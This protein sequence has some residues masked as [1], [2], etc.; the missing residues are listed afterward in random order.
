[1]SRHPY[2]YTILRYRH[3]PVS[4]EQLNVGVIVHSPERQFLRGRFRKGYGRLSKAFPDVDGSVLR[5]DLQRIERAF[6]KLSKR[7]SEDLFF[8]GQTASSFARQVVAPDDGSLLWSEIGSGTTTDPESTL[9]KLFFR[10]VTQY[11][12]T[13]TVRRTDADVWRP[14]R[15]KL[16]ELKVASIFEK[17]TI[18][19]PKDEVEFEH[20][21]K[22][23]RWH[24]Y[25]PLSFDLATI[26]GI[27][28]KAARWVGHMVGLS[29]ASEQF[30]PY[31]IVGKPSE[32]NLIPAYNRAVS[33]IAD[34]PMQPTIV[35]EDEVDTFASDLADRV[36]EHDQSR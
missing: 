36:N 7:E 32:P 6:E 34:A 26:D 29:S 21:W 8:A 3:D 20:A 28:E 10:F 9:E 12:E 22:N 31:F 16:M 23:G 4:G 19:S 14:F 11:E 13:S 35:T 2:T 18:A 1:M 30:H 5:N 27:Q 25:Q 17:K 24:C 33:F 15:D